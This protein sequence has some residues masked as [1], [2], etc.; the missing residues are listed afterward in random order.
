MCIRDSPKTPKPLWGRELES[1][2]GSD[3]ELRSDFNKEYQLSAGHTAAVGLGRTGWT[4]GYSFLGRR[5]ELAA[6]AG[7]LA[8]G[9]EHRAVP[10]GTKAPL[11]VSYTHLTLPTNREV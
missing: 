2:F 5:Q 6:S 9:W 4:W 1:K 11:A 8:A 7:S 3:V 10:P